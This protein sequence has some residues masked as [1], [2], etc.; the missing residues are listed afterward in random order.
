VVPQVEEAWVAH[1]LSGSVLAAMAPQ[2]PFTPLP[3]LAA[4]QAWQLPP[5]EE[6]Q[7]KPSAQNP[8]AQLDER[9]QAVP[10]ARVATQA[11]A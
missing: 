11:P 9:E 7:Q 3:F 10:L 8:D 6:L 2:V 5:Q 4:E 1:S